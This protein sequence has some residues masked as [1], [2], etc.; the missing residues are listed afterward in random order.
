MLYFMTDN[1]GSIFLAVSVRSKEIL[2]SDKNNIRIFSD[3]QAV[4]DV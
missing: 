4:I 1:V 3:N 2:S